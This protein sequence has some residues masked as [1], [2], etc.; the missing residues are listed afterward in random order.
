MAHGHDAPQR[1]HLHGQRLLPV[2]PAREKQRRLARSGLVFHQTKQRID[3]ASVDEDLVRVAGRLGG[4]VRGHAQVNAHDQRGQRGDDQHK[5][6]WEGRLVLRGRG[7]VRVLLGLRF[8]AGGR[9]IVRLVL[10]GRLGAGRGGRAWLRRLL[11]LLIVVSHLLLLGRCVKGHPAE[12]LEVDLGPGMRVLAGH[13]GEAVRAGLGHKSLH[14]A[15]G[16]ARHAA[17]H[18]HG[19]SKV[20][21]IPLLAHV[22]E[23]GDEVLRIGRDVGREGIAV[24]ALQVAH[25]GACLFVGGGRGGGYVIDVRQHALGVRGTGQMFGQLQIAAADLVIIGVAALGRRGDQR[26]QLRI[27]A[28]QNGGKDG[29]AVAALQIARGEELAAVV[30]VGD[31][32]GL[33]RKLAQKQGGEQRAGGG[34]LHLDAH[35]MFV[36]QSARAANHVRGHVLQEHAFPKALPARADVEAAPGGAGAA[37]GQAGV[38]V[39]GDGAQQRARIG[40]DGHDR[41]VAGLGGAAQ[42]GVA[43]GIVAVG[44]QGEHVAR[45]GKKQV[46]RNGLAKL[47]RLV[48]E[49]L[50]HR[51]SGREQQHGQRHHRHGHGQHLKEVGLFMRGL[52]NQKQQRHQRGRCVP[53]VFRLAQAPHAEEH[54]HHQNSGGKKADVARGKQVADACDHHAQGKA[55]LPGKQRR[56]RLHAVEIQGHGLKGLHGPADQ[57][58]L[59]QGQLHGQQGGAGNAQDQPAAAEGSQHGAQH[60]DRHRR[61]D[62]QR[63]GALRLKGEH[64]GKQQPHG[65]QQADQKTRQAFIGQKRRLTH[66]LPPPFHSGFG[67]AVTRPAASH[68]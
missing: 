22:E 27:S 9:L 1:Q 5:P 15:R 16:Q 2:Q 12:A 42:T 24:V 68:S 6:P 49:G 44:A 52:R 61:G 34:I 39:L 56:G 21:A 51:L 13:I 19:R 11:V 23:V 25:D 66:G 3:G 58:H 46:V 40:L 17:Q 14:I 63:Q 38:F 20:G 10:F 41:R 35:G 65:H 64:Q 54:Q 7:H 55:Q 31:H 43:L 45:V 37:P 30:E 32:V 26:A 33:R 67:R 8:G 50:D 29:I 4:H 62:G 53:Q 59:G 57:A 18:R 28:L 47:H 60:R 48:I 36:Q